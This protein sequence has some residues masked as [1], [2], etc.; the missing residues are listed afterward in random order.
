MEITSILW[1]CFFEHRFHIES[2]FFESL[3][4]SLLDSWNKLRIDHK[5]HFIL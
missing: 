2:G 3:L 1:N 4:T 5:F